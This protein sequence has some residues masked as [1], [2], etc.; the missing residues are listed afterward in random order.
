MK[1]LMHNGKQM[2]LPESVEENRLVWHRVRELLEMECRH[3][4][5]WERDETNIPDVSRAW[6]QASCTFPFSRELTPLTMHVEEILP[7][8]RPLEPLV[9]VV[10]VGL[11]T[12]FEN[13][14]LQCRFSGHMKMEDRGRS[15]F[16]TICERVWKAQRGT[17]FWFG[18]EMHLL[19]AVNR[20]YQQG[21]RGVV[22][23]GEEEV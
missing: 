6:Y 1:Y 17:K 3:L 23:H 19:H 18:N 4:L 14:S 9:F 5:L 12:D 16:Q 10:D 22:K 7:S 15:L 11:P 8:T 21:F 2:Y 13:Q 20:L